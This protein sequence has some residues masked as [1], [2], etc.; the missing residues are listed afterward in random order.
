MSK[1]NS[2]V[3]GI[4]V[5]SLI[6][7]IF[8]V[9]SFPP[10][11]LFPISFVALI[12][13]CI[14]IYKADKIRYYVLSAAVFVF[15][16]FSYLLFWVSAFMLKETAVFV[17]FL[18]LFTILF[19]LVLLFYLPAFLLS[20]FLSHKLPH[21]RFLAIP[22]VFTVMEYTRTLGFL[23]FP[24]GI[25]G[26]S[27]WNFPI[28][29]QIAD[30][31]GVLGIS[32][33]VYLTNAI[34]AHY[35]LL[36]AESKEHLDN[37]KTF[38]PALA[39]FLVIILIFIYGFIKI[40]AE[41]SKR[42]R[43]PKTTVALIQKSFDPNIYWRNI[44]TGEPFRKGSKGIGAFAEKFLLKS[45]KFQS[46]ELPD[47]VSQNGTI[48]VK[49]LSKLAKDAA[50]SKPSLIIYPETATMDAYS[51]YLN[52][53]RES[54]EYGMA[55]NSI[56]PS[57]NNT[58]ILYETIRN[59]QTYHLLGTILI[60]ENTNSNAYD[61]YEYYNGMEFIDGRGNVVDDYAKKKLVPGGEAYPF[62]DNEFLLNTPPFSYIV[63]AIHDQFRKAG[64]GGWAI[65]K[66]YTVFKH[67][68][69]YTF[70][71]LICYES[72]FGDF[73]RKFVYDGAELLAVITEDAWSYSDESLEQHFYMSVFRAIE[74][75]RDLV[76]NGNS[77]VTGHI[78]STGKIIST[79]PYWIPD[80]LIAN[81]ALNNDMTI[82]TRFGEWFVY[83]CFIS[84]LVLLY[85]II[86]KS[87][88]NIKKKIKDFFSNRTKKKNKEEISIFTDCGS[89]I[90]DALTDIIEDDEEKEK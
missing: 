90:S 46:E 35:I 15:A 72:A 36:Y 17:A 75:R 58:Y 69:G 79:L 37:K 22:I 2:Y 67:P 20:G 64:A 12:P 80:Y 16:F 6:S 26:Y 88:S 11:N 38:I 28:F 66:K 86:H 54:F 13:L 44:Y 1:N 29:I 55:S 74:N 39:S 89:E 31:V 4:I 81:V 25:L 40:N 45:D 59:T 43:L 76:H 61:A 60:K 49:R 82:Y 70:S 9:L 57:V 77:G 24:W 7:V 78:S 50:L 83:L 14:I 42:F 71:G 87:F 51:Y 34:I 62:Q 85:L 18:A 41:E 56:Y 47:G 73:A 27:Q 32:F 5:L 65:G 33:F 52:Q 84:I 8:L 63:K 23:G 53:N 48:T 30:M 19:L 68:N 3:Y 10:L 21:L